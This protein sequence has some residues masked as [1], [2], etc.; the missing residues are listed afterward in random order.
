LIAV[1]SRFIVTCKPEGGLVMR[2]IVVSS[3]AALAAIGFAATAQAD[4]D[5][6]WGGHKTASTPIPA[7]TA[8]N[9]KT[10]PQTT[11]PTKKTRAQTAKVSKT[12]KGG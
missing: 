2:K 3:I 8:D 10:L 11:I 7:V 6:G 4:G 9:T 1:F 12:E 5:C